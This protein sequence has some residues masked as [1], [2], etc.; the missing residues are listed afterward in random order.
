MVPGV[1][2]LVR[3]STLF[4]IVRNRFSATTEHINCSSA[5]LYR[6]HNDNK[7]YAIVSFDEGH[8]I[9]ANSSCKE[10]WKKTERALPSKFW[11]A[12]GDKFCL[13]GGDHVASSTSF[14]MSLFLQPHPL[15]NKLASLGL[16]CDR[17]NERFMF[18]VDKPALH[19]AEQGDA[20]TF[21]EAEY[22]S[23]FM[24]NVFSSL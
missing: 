21:M 2:Y 1:N 19:V 4:V 6:H 22:G 11:N 3:S 23:D 10:G 15:L 7:N 24:R 9:L 16:E 5:G 17:F 13:K 12:K 8:R 14:S 20:A 18:F